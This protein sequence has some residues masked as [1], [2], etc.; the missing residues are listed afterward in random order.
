[1]G[2]FW[3]R[4]LLWSSLA[5]A[6]WGLANMPCDGGRLKP[7]LQSAGFPWTFA[8]WNWGQ[9]EFFSGWEL[10]ADFALG[11]AVAGGLAALCSW[12][13]SPRGTGRTESASK[14]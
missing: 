1:M 2:P 6:V 12:A 3:R 14:A 10:A 9:L 13:R 8:S 4:F 11:I 7:F 5:F